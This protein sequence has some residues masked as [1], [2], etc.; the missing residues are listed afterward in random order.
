[1]TH[2]SSYVADA[3][4]GRKE[5]ALEHF[6]GCIHP[7]KHLYRWLPQADFP[8]GSVGENLPTM[9][10]TQQEMWVQF[11][12]GKTPWRRKWL[13]LRCS[14][15]ENPMDRGACWATVHGV[16]KELG[17]TEHEHALP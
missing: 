5:R 2:P 12:A 17:M 6:W 4:C 9:Q 3:Q 8:G 16:A 14:Y 7:E 1:M 15:L 13:P 10:E 11:W